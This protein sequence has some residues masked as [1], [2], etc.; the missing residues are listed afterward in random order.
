MDSR[1]RLGIYSSK[2]ARVRA[3]ELRASQ[4]AE[5]QARIR[6]REEEPSVGH[7]V[8]SFVSKIGKKVRSLFGNED[9]TDDKKQEEK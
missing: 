4:L 9:V 7:E 3:E 8:R 2:E 1:S 5:Y 6:K